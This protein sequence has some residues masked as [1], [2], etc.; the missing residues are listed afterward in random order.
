VFHLLDYPQRYTFFRRNEIISQSFFS[1]ERGF[2]YSIYL[3]LL[4]PP[5][6]QACLREQINLFAIINKFTY[7]GKVSLFI[8]A[9]Q[10]LAPDA[11]SLLHELGT[12]ALGVVGRRAG[13]GRGADRLR[14]GGTEKVG[15]S[16]GPIATAKLRRQAL[17]EFVILLLGAAVGSLD[18][19]VVKARQH[20]EAAG[21][22]AGLAHTTDAAAKRG[23]HA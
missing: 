1:R 12:G 14:L 7:E 6:K 16:Q 11:G 3:I 22:T 19:T 20:E 21:G 13:S 18:G 23:R 5:K 9:L 4:Y 10:V 15:T 2:L 17:Y 8:L